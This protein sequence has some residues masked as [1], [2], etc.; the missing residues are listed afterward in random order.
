MGCKS[1]KSADLSNGAGYYR[2]Y[3]NYKPLLSVF[4]V[5]K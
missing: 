2:L 1:L 4:I 3:G 5:R